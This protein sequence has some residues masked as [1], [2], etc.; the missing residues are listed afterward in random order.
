MN[1]QLLR[2]IN[3]QIYSF[4]RLFNCKP[5]IIHLDKSFAI[6]FHSKKKYMQSLITGVSYNEELSEETFFLLAK[7]L[8]KS[9]ISE[10]I[11]A[12]SMKVVPKY[13]N[14]YLLTWSI[15]E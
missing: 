9:K 7:G 4:Q 5:S 11:L 12:H 8:L 14:N 1:M 13:K 6:C 15:L 3:G 10:C 2:K